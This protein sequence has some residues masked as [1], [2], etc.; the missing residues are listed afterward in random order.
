MQI[1]RR[2][3]LDR[4]GGL[5]PRILPGGIE[6][7]TTCALSTG[8]GYERRP[9]PVSVHTTPEIWPSAVACR[10]Q[11]GTT[12]VHQSFR[13]ACGMPTDRRSNT[14]PQGPPRWAKWGEVVIKRLENDIVL[15]LTRVTTHS[16]HRSLCLFPQV[17]KLGQVWKILFGAFPPFGIKS[18]TGAV[19]SGGWVSKK[20]NLSI[21]ANV[22]DYARASQK[23][24]GSSIIVD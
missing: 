1:R 21:K 6:R 24:R 22:Y 17:E 15:A 19:T 8:N 20:I 4:N 3:I 23:L 12:Y 11:S 5:D 18:F 13:R 14:A 7:K 16:P 10:S 2:K 9:A